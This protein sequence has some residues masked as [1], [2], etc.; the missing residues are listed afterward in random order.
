MN[1]VPAVCFIG[2]VTF[3]LSCVGVFIGNR[4]GCKYKSK[5][6]FAGGLVL[7]IMGIKILLE[8]TIMG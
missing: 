2:I 7:I 6:E 4:F 3:V 5:A 8:H 1:I